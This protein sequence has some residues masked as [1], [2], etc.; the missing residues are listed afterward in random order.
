MW[1]KQLLPVLCEDLRHQYIA[2][3]PVVHIWQKRIQFPQS[4]IKV[5]AASN[6]YRMEG[7]LLII[8]V[9][10]AVHKAPDQFWFRFQFLHKL[11]HGR[12]T[13]ANYIF[14]VNGRH[15]CPVKVPVFQV[16]Q[17][18]EPLSDDS[19]STTHIYNPSA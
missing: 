10:Q 13:D 5:P 18:E 8:P 16:L 17:S 11:A 2:G 1:G 15:Q 19:F 7:I 4:L 9:R 3:C 6:Q 14:T 12:H